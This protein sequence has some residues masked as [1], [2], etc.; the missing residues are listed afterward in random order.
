MSRLFGIT[1]SYCEPEVLAHGLTRFVR[2]AGEV[3]EKY[4]I[5]DHLWPINPINNSIL[6]NRLALIVF[7]DVIKPPMNGGGAYGFNYAME[8]LGVLNDDDLIIGMDPDSNPI[9]PNW[10]TAMVAT[11]RASK[12]LNS[13][14]LMHEHLVD[15]P[16]EHEFIGGSKVSF[17]PHPEMMNVTIWRAGSIRGG[18]KSLGLYGHNERL[19]WKPKTVGYLYD[20]RE[21]ICPI[22]HPKAYNDWKMAYAFNGYPHN[23]D[24]W[25]KEIKQ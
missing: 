1:V 10:L 6:V 8:H 21:T 7:G 12:E 22:Q 24:Q 9:T 17:L 14:S 13:V 23:F 4:V 20:Y 19:M 11:M 16:W 2:T 5:V 25:L 3:P 15:R 18:M